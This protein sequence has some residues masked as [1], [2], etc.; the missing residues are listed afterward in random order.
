MVN[1]FNSRPFRARCE[2]Q[3][4][5]MAEILGDELL[6]RLCAH[7]EHAPKSLVEDFKPFKNLHTFES[8]ILLDAFVG[9]LSQDLA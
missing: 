4:E 3:A 1:I 9:G 2:V 7:P 8:V 6:N 5:S